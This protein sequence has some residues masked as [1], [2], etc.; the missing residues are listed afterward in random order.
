MN[1]C[2]E[3]EMFNNRAVKMDI[4][5]NNIKNDLEKI[6]FVENLINEIEVRIR[7]RKSM[8]FKRMKKLL[9][10]LGDLRFDLEFEDYK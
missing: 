5:R 2:F 6:Q 3:Y 1:F 7:K 8:D 4:I 9:S 10:T